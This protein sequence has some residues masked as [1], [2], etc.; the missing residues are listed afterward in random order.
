MKCR[1]FLEHVEY[2]IMLSDN[3]TIYTK[4][5]FGEKCI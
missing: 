1:Q 3:K 4:L 2:F 5:K